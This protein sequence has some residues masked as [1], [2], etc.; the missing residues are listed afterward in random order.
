MGLT[1]FAIRQAKATGH[2]YTLGDSDGLSLAISAQ[3]R[4]SWHFRY[5]SRATQKRMSLGTYFKLSA[6]VREAS[7]TIRLSS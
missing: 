4:K 3:G 7:T 1:D 5:Y 6:V 2:P